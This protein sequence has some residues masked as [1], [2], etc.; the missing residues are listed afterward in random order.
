MRRLALSLLRLQAAISSTVRKQPRQV[1]L[2][3]RQQWRM[4][5]EATALS[6]AAACRCAGSGIDIDAGALG[7]G[8]R[9]ARGSAAILAAPAVMLAAGVEGAGQLLSA[10]VALAPLAA[11]PLPAW[12][13]SAGARLADLRRMRGRVTRHRIQLAGTGRNRA[14]GSQPLHARIFGYQ[15]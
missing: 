12:R 7:R 11:A 1:S 2:A 14:L 10:P 8:D 4:Q 15:G 13:R 3:S 6:D 9:L 5:G